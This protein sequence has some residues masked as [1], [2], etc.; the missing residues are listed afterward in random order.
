[1]YTEYSAVSGRPL[2][3][4][5]PGY[6]R[7]PETNRVRKTTVG[8]PTSRRS[9][10]R[11]TV[12]SVKKTKRSTGGKT[13][14]QSRA[15]VP[16]RSSSRAEFVKPKSRPD[17]ARRP[18]T[19]PK[20]NARRSTRTVVTKKR[21]TTRETTVWC[22]LTQLEA[23]RLILTVGLGRDLHPRDLPTAQYPNKLCQTLTGMLAASCTQGWQV[24][25]FIAAGAYGHVF[26]A[27]KNDGTKGVMKVQVGSAE[28][29]RHEVKIQNSFGRK[30]LAPKILGY[31]S[32][33]PRHWMGKVAH[34][35]LQNVV[36]NEDA[37]DIEP[38]AK[39]HLV[40][41]ILM[42]EIAGVVGD[43]LA[44]PKSQEQLGQLTFDI[45]NL[46][47][48]FKKHKLT[49]ADMHLWNLGYVYTDASKKHMSL[50]PIDFGRSV[51][52]KANPELELG[53]LLRALHPSLSKAVPQFNRQVIVNLIRS[54]SPQRFG[55][56]FPGS[57]K[58]AADRYEEQLNTHME[59]AGLW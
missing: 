25:K 32:F 51:V 47:D 35:G 28:E 6:E 48:D 54:L 55:I 41:I 38:H 45:M 7:N 26:R 43:W 31:C 34:M 23:R 13:T 1:M 36:Q 29:I 17:K 49:H 19:K 8:K 18:T 4:I 53:C 59:E 52:G 24:T 11:K 9:T 30:G 42:E 46:V 50:M 40:H 21:V 58:D 56:S 12:S 44:N 5:P 37:D 2:K 14:R 20:P 16:K 39:G 57:L 22:E 10:T 33:K 3:A 27:V 15:I